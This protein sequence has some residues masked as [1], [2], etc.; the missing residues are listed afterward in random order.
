MKKTLLAALFTAPC[1]LAAFSAAAALPAGVALNAQAAPKPAKKPKPDLKDVLA[2]LEK[3]LKAVEGALAEK[4]GQAPKYQAAAAHFEAAWS[5]AFAL[6]GVMP[7]AIA[8]NPKNK[9]A[10]GAV[11]EAMAA[12]AKQGQTAANAQK[13]DAVKTALAEVR[14]LRDK[15]AAVAAPKP[16]AK[17]P[18]KAK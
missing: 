9:Q 5:Q 16:D 17:A 13:A 12:A 11:V 2:E 8:K 6:N 18:A 3:E 4:P 1:L 14:R 7:P 10:F 15:L